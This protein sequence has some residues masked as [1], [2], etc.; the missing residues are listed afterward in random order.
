MSRELLVGELIRRAAHKTP[1][2]L[3]F[4][5]EDE[6]LTYEQL[7][8]K[9]MHLAGWLQD[10]GIGMGDKVGFIFKNHI[11]FVEVFFGVA[12]SGGVGVPM[13]FRLV[14]EEFIY[15]INDSDT[16]ILIIEEE[17]V[18]II[19]SIRHKLP[20]VEKVVV[21]G[22]NHGPYI[23]YND[24]YDIPSTYESISGQV[25]DNDDCMIVYTS[26]T[27]GKPKGAVLTH[28]NLVVNAQNLI[29][30]FELDL[31]FKQIIISPLFHVAAI[32]CLLMGCSVN[33][34]TVIRRDFDAVNILDTIE[35]EE[36]NCIFLVPAMWNMVINVPNI[37]KYN[38]SSMK[39]CM[40]GAAICPAEIKKKIMHY[41]SN[42]GMYDI[43]GQTEMSPSTTCLHPKDSIRKTTSV[44][45]PIINV[46]VRVVDENMNDV[47]VGE[48]GEII[49]RGPTLMKEY[50]K[51]REA[52]EES[53]YGG[54]FHSGD[55]VRMDEEGFIYVVDRK[56]DMLISG[57]ENIYPAEVE[58]VLYKHEAILETAV[59]GVPDIDW[60]ESV[61]AYIVLKPG[62]QLTKEDI[63]RHCNKYLASYK[64]P[65]FV[66]FINELPR[67]TSGKVL[68]RVLKEQQNVQSQ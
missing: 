39:K 59:V 8:K 50:Y 33:G 12:L 45:K 22:D 67:N 41:F 34:T 7:E 13:N 43:F 37:E 57:G 26:G 29:W 48:I 63:I 2:K 36:I 64:K 58:A 25:T 9:T 35:K 52:T 14:A 18:N 4:S 40:T 38:L 31:G 30:E 49:Y 65:R 61:K 66:E 10:S 21:V 46:E 47:P 53:F 5:Y 55:L 15:I 42:A 23:A 51:K 3:A 60:G 19:Q 27:T 24:I 68:K 32:A 54:W 28:K 62:Q 16:K 1:R 56:K 6:T 44:G 17:Y 20:N 11:A